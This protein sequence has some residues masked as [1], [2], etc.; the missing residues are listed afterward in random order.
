MKIYRVPI[1][2]ILIGLGGLLFGQ[3]I[4]TSPYSSFGIGEI[5]YDNSIEQAGMG[6]LSALPTNPFNASANFYNPAANQNLSVTSFQFDTNTRLSRFNDGFSKSSKST[7]YLSDVS[8]AFPIGSKIRAGFGFQPYSAAGYDLETSSS[9]E[10]LEYRN[11]F[12]GR[13]GLNSAHVMASYNISPSFTVGA[14]GNF[15]FGTLKR[16]QVISTKGFELVTDYG[17]QSR[18]NGLQFTLGTMYTK[19][20]DKNKRL[21]VTAKYTFGSNIDAQVTDYTSTYA[22]FDLIPTNVDTVRY[23][24]K[25]GSLRV[26]QSVTLAAS[27]RKELRWMVGLQ[28][29]WGNWGNYHL[30][31]DDN[32]HIQ[33]RFRL[34]GG[35]YWLP[36]FNSY[37]S[38]FERVVYRFGVFYEAT[39]LR[40]EDKGV[41]KYGFAVG[42]GLPVGKDRDASMFN[43]SAEFGQMGK[44][45]KEILRENY[46]QLKIGFTLNDFWFRK[47]VID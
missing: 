36:N 30:T 7:T 35:G 33:T 34:A 26:P 8:L 9:F 42:M 3:T 23:V 28:F 37:K 22:L 31:L 16:N 18:M 39:P 40:F 21:D 13:G 11:S 20:L 46:V 38:Y 29:D 32:S 4:A 45:N 19:R 17:F 24:R 44:A 1:L 6:G 14:R 43:L 2:S 5:L 12:T 27:L 41:R 47:R 10:D 15:L 25:N